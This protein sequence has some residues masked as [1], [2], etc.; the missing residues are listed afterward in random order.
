MCTHNKSFGSKI[1]ETVYPCV[2][3]FKGYICYENVILKRYS[4]SDI[5]ILKKRQKEKT[6]AYKIH[7][8]PLGDDYVYAYLHNDDALDTATPPPTV[9]PLRRNNKDTSK[10]ENDKQ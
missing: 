9:V 7:F 4:N 10:G 3:L 8:R 5:A 6:M 1:R 2:L